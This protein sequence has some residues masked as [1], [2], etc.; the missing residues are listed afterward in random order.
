MVTYSNTPIAIVH[1]R[2]LKYLTY[3]YNLCNAAEC[4]ITYDGCASELQCIAFRILSQTTSVSN[5]ERNWGMFS[6]VHAKTRNSL[7]YKK[8]NIIVYLRYN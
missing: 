4:W 6:L 1:M 8:L 5:Y 2:D 3:L 7:S